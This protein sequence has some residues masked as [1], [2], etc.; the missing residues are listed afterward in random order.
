MSKKAEEIQNLNVEF[1]LINT[2][3]QLKLN[4]ENSTIQI[5]KTFKPQKKPLETFLYFFLR[6]KSFQNRRSVHVSKIDR[7]VFG[8]LIG[9]IV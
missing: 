3:N 8:N 5:W 2:S 9:N 1:N 6:T 4:F 7:N